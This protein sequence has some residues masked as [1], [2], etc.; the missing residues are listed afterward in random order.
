MS[1]RCCHYYLQADDNK[2][3]VIKFTAMICYD[4]SFNSDSD[5]Y[6]WDPVHLSLIK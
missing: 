1:I 4:K 2:A 3:Y 5:D 6:R